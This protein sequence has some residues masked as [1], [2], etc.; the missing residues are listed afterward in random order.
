MIGDLFAKIWKS[1]F[2]QNISNIINR[3]I[4]V[5][6]Y[7]KVL[8][9][10]VT[11]NRV[12]AIQDTEATFNIESKEE[13][14][15]LYPNFEHEKPILEALLTEVRDTDVFYDI[16]GNIG[17]YSVMLGQ[18]IAKGEIYAFEPLAGNVRRLEQNLRRN[19]VNGEVFEMALS[20]TTGTTTIFMRNTALV[21]EGKS[22]LIP[23]QEMPH[24]RTI[25][26][27]TGDDFVADHTPP[28]VLKIDV[29]GAELDVLRGFRETFETHGVRLIYCEV[30]SESLVDEIQQFLTDVG[31][32]VES[33]TESGRYYIKARQ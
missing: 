23:E 17:L 21:G 20:D 7:I 30:H 33:I 25:Q 31:F 9:A 28:D 8:L 13:Y 12:I 18:R 16:G 11:T 3:Y 22:T 19:D 10:R 24:S 5:N 26:S 2:V 27:M 4:S 15:E 6:E 14:V 29:E 32:E 1:Q